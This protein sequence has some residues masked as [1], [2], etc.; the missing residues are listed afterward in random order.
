[1][2][3]ADSNG[4]NANINGDAVGI[5]GT[6]ARTLPMGTI[7]SVLPKFDGKNMPLSD[8]VSRLQCTLKIYN[9]SPD[10]EVDIALTALE[11]EARRNVCLQPELTR[12]TL[13]ELVKFLEEI[14]GETA[15]AGHLRA[16]FFSKLQREEEGISQYATALQ[17]VFEEVQR[18]EADGLGGM[19]SKDR[20]L[21][22]QFILGLHSTSLRQALSARVRADPALTFRQVMA[23]TVARS[24][25]ESYASGAFRV[26]FQYLQMTLNSA[27]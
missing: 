13:K 22:E 18:K 8:W 10:L 26:E 21:R 4:G 3:A 14:Y 17:E 24:K 6:P 23:E 7:F 19:G 27:G 1:M 20:I 12:S 11:G 16:K 15:S 25:E 2:E 9:I 5:G